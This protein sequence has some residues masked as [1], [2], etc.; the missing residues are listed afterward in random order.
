MMKKY[1]ILIPSY[2]SKLHDIVKTFTDIPV[3]SDVFVIDDGSIVPFAD[4]VG[5]SLNAFQNL[6]I[7][8]LDVNC[9]IENAL[10]KGL[11]CIIDNYD[12]V[13]RLDIGDTCQAERYLQQANFLAENKDYSIIGCWASFYNEKGQ[14]LFENKTP[15]SDKE[16]RKKMF[17]NNMFVHP[18]VMMRCSSIKK[19]GVY[20]KK[21]PACE[22]YDLFFRLLSVGKGM[23]IPKPWVHYEVNSQSISS[24][25]RKEQ[26]RN[27]LKII[28][29][30]FSLFE[31]GI[32]PYYGLIRN[33]MLLFM[34]RNISTKLRK[35]LIK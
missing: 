15:V 26:V 10:N 11:E 1:A 2:N 16:I 21:Y 4:V 25:K 7:I 27:R 34:S 32:Y 6:K 29:K 23:N 8:R 14:F 28:I 24:T 3:N 12:F 13:A 22:D 17:I 35:F 33:L 19:V 5:S 30:Y 31:Y 20:S 9:G 18:S